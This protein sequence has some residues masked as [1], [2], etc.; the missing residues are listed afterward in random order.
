MAMM[1]NIDIRIAVATKPKEMALVDVPKSF[2][3]ASLSVDCGGAGLE[4]QNFG[5]SPNPFMVFYC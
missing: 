4:L 1:R 3:A 5:L 2:R